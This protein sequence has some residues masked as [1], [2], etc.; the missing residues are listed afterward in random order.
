MADPRSAGVANQRT[1]TTPRVLSYKID[2]TDIVYEAAPITNGS[3]KA[4][5]AVMLSGNGIVRL[6]ADGARVLGRLLKVDDDG[7]CSVQVG[8]VVQLP[9]SG[10]ITV[11]T[12]IVGALL[13]AARGYVRSE[14]LATLADVANAAH[15]VL[16]VSDVNNIEID[17][18]G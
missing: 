2:G 17:L 11:N 15:N 6:T 7:W 4:G 18:V 10:T 13:S 14:V 9:S 3:S 12:Q 5:L 1:G 8:G 16:D